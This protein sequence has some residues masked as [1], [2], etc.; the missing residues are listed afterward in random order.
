MNNRGAK[1]LMLIAIAGLATA[2]WYSR[3]NLAP[4][5][6]ED[7]TA[8]ESTLIDTEKPVER[9]PRNLCKYPQIRRMQPPAVKHRRA[10]SL[11]CS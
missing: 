4:E 5:P 9:G 3:A 8:V 6:E 1:L 2:L 10:P 11:I 7:I